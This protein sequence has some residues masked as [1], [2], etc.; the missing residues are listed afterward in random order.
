MQKLIQSFYEL[1]RLEAKEYNLK[2]EKLDAK[3]LIE[4]M[5]GKIEVEVNDCWIYFRVEFEIDEN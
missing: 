4:N 2:L 1:F 5:D 3:L